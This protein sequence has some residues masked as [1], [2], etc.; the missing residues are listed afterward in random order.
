M[1][2]AICAARK[3]ARQAIE[4]TYDGVATIIEH[5]K[6]KDEQ[7][8]LTYF[9]DK[10]ILENQ[11]CKLS[12]KNLSTAKQGESAATITQTIE[13]FISPDITIKPNSKIIVT[14]AGVTTDYTYSGV[15][16]VYDTH[17]QIILE[18]FTEWS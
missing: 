2:E 7:S 3:A 6:I 1:V 9:K 18:L 4:S 15:P 11:P 5:H 10:V 13:L 17:Q 16:A 14:Q 8:K 12:F